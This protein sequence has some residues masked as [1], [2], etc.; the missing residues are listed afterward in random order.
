MKRMISTFVILGFVVLSTPTFYSSAAE[1]SSLKCAMPN[2]KNAYKSAKAVFI[3]KVVKVSKK[4]DRKV[5]KFKV[6]KYWKG[7]ENKYVEVSVYENRRFQSPYRK[8]RSYLVF[9]KSR[10]EGGLWDG[11]C[12]RSRDVEGFSPSLK[13]D[14]KTLGEAKTCISLDK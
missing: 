1:E 9:A 10:E 2:F 13:D 14:L 11:R 7:V 5:T 8:D 3:G 12:S 6:T 4:G